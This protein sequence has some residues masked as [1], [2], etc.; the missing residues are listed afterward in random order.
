MV[1]IYQPYQQYSGEIPSSPPQQ[2]Q[3]KVQWN[4]SP[5]DKRICRTTPNKVILTA[6]IFYFHLSRPTFLVLL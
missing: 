1:Q 6:E 2:D 3:R 4:F 5:I